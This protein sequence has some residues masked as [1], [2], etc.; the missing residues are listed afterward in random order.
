[1]GFVGNASINS[2]ECQRRYCRRRARRAA[3]G[4]AHLLRQLLVVVIS[5][6][7]GSNKP[8]ESVSLISNTG[9]EIKT[10]IKKKQRPETIKSQWLI[11]AMEQLATKLSGLD[12]ECIDEAISEIADKQNMRS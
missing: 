10:T 11:L 2:V 5:L 6:F 8:E 7:D 12:L 4:R 1:M 9:R 3:Q